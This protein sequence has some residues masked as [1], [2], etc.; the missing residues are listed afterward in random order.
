MSYVVKVK[1]YDVYWSGIS[2]PGKV[3]TESIHDCQR[4]DS[5]EEADV[6]ANSGNNMESLEYEVALD[7]PGSKIPDWKKI[8]VGI[9]EARKRMKPKGFGVHKNDDTRKKEKV[10]EFELVED[11]FVEL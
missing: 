2:E 1:G 8:E 10:K 11:D 3:W 5:K 7:N 6:I 4:F 9:I